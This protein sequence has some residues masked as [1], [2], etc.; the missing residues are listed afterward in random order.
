MQVHLHIDVIGT[1]EATVEN[2]EL[3]HSHAFVASWV[4]TG[5]GMMLLRHGQLQIGPLDGSLRST[6]T[7]PQLAHHSNKKFNCERDGG[8]CPCLFQWLATMQ[9]GPAIQFFFVLRELSLKETASCGCRATGVFSKISVPSA[10][11]QQKAA[12]CRRRH[13]FLEGL[14]RQNS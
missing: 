10:Y 7:Q 3:R 11:E 4:W 12:L 2:G 1:K 14:F 13:R 9:R 5:D 6:F 8:E